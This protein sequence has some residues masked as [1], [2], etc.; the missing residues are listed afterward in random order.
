MCTN[1]VEFSGI[2]SYFNVNTDVNNIST[3]VFDFNIYIEISKNFNGSNDIDSNT[4]IFSQTLK[5]VRIH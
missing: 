2:S 3:Y 1:F 5:T 4:T